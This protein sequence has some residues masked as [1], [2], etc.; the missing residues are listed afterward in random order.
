M[1]AEIC[2]W[3][4][5]IAFFSILQVLVLHLLPSGEQ[6]KYV[7]FFMGMVFL[8]VLLEPLL[9]LEGGEMAFNDIY[10]KAALE[11][12]VTIFE[13]RQEKLEQK[14]EKYAEQMQEG[15]ERENGKEAGES[16][17][18]PVRIRVG[19]EKTFLP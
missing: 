11:Q 14:I 3:I 10:E 16:L 5:N 2:K 15:E 18:E 13:E 8:I 4:E 17:V 6:Q 1:V 9:T 12:E 19:G 7:R